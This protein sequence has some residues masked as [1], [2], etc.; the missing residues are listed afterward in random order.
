MD[1]SFLLEKIYDEDEKEFFKEILNCINV[2][3][4]RAAYVMI[5]VIIGESLKNKMKIMSKKDS[6]VG[7][8]YKK[9][10]NSN[11][12]EEI[13]VQAENIG[14][15]SKEE[16]F[17][18]ESIRQS[19]HSYAHPTGNYPLKEDVCCDLRRAVDIV[20]SKP[21]MYSYSYINEFIKE[22]LAIDPFYL[23][24]SDEETIQ[25]FAR[26]FFD[27]LIPS[28][29]DYALKTLFESSE[30]LIY[31]FNPVSRKCLRNCLIFLEELILKII[32]EDNEFP[33]EEYLNN[34]KYPS[35]IVF[36]NKNIW[37]L[38]SE[39][40]KDRIF[41]YYL[42][43]NNK[44]LFQIDFINKFYK[45]SKE[46]LLK[47]DFKNQLYNFIQ[48]IDYDALK[49][50]DIDYNWYF[51]KIIKDMKSY[52]W[53]IQNPAIEFLFTLD[54]KK[55]SD[56]NLEI[57]GRN[58]YQ[59]AVGSSDSAKFFIKNFYTDNLD[60]D[61]PI[62][63]INGIYLE[64]L[65]N[66]EKMFRFKKYRFSELFKKLLSSTFKEEVF[67]NLYV[68]LENSLLKNNDFNEF[69]EIFKF[70]DKFLSQNNSKEMLKLK[71]VLYYLHCK[72]IQNVFNNKTD[73]YRLDSFKVGIAPFL[74]KCLTENQFL[75]FK[76]QINSKDKILD[77]LNFISEYRNDG[78]GQFI[79]YFDDFF[80]DTFI[81][82]N[83][84]DEIFNDL[85]DNNSLSNN[86]QKIINDF[87]KE[88]L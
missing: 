48:E 59:A 49:N 11:I 61:V 34:F 24:D 31:D 76:S 60:K 18:L 83:E 20:L 84:I 13:L 37:P 77:F 6:T 51:D 66:E 2:D 62:S 27:K 58:I 32:S 70:I 52:D 1:Y 30:K 75:E 80:I 17:K 15:I 78:N 23:G 4:Y 69:L 56:E 35:C 86:E 9:I 5:W 67:E 50:T 40:S 43:S 46:N 21:P 42:E 81:N 28:T 41:N 73:F 3:A 12:D 72:S 22:N 88:F 64:I 85:I 16:R 7:K 8:A 55:F 33:T 19:R 87:R 79:N 38:L 45:L 29:Y 10:L 63:L 39:R 44:F 26:S 54:L 65:V 68:N 25:E 47:E 71:E 57:I 14:F 82:L 74:E 36:T 53:Y